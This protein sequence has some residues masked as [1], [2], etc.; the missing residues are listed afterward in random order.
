MQFTIPTP[1]VEFTFSDGEDD[2]LFER[3]SI[4]IV[5]NNS[6]RRPV[7][8]EK[9]I[10][11]MHKFIDSV[12]HYPISTVFLNCFM[13]ELEVELNNHFDGNGCFVGTDMEVLERV[14]ML[15][16]SIE[17]LSLVMPLGR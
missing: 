14:E 5:P 15:I 11:T 7:Y 17:H 2:E 3:N 16:N 1:D 6:P 9:S 4:P 12:A 10:R 8:E 13:N